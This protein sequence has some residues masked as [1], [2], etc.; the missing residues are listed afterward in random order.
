MAADPTAPDPVSA[1]ERGPEV[2]TASEQTQS[3]HNTHL[4]YIKMYFVPQS[5][6]NLDS[7]WP[8][9]LVVFPSES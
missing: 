2:H 5:R 8:K 1:G 3:R 6:C 4:N 9:M 7:D